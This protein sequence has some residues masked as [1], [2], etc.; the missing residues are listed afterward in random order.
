M[1]FVLVALG[2][3]LPSL[4]GSLQA[5]LV[6]FDAPQLG[7]GSLAEIPGLS[8]SLLL[9]FFV[10]ASAS[11]LSL[12]MALG[13][14]Y[15]LALKSQFKL[16]AVVVALWIAIPHV[17]FAALFSSFLVPQSFIP[18]PQ[19]L[20][21]DPSGLG[22][23]FTLAGK[24]IPFLLLLCLGGLAQIP[25]RQI[26]QNTRVLGKS[27]QEAYLQVILPM[28]IP[29]IRFGFCI[30]CVYS[31]S[32]LDISLMIGPTNPPILAQLIFEYFNQASIESKQL[33]SLLMLV[34]IC[35]GGL[36]ALLG[37]AVLEW[38]KKCLQASKFAPKLLTEKLV[39]KFF[40]IGFYVLVGLLAVGFVQLVLWSFAWRWEQ[41]A[42]LPLELSLKNWD[43]VFSG[44][45][46]DALFNSL[47]LGFLTASIA[48]LL[49]IGLSL[50]RHKSIPS[51]WKFFFLMPL[52]IPQI[53]LVIGAWL[54]FA[55]Y[56]LEFASYLQLLSFHLLYALAYL[57]FFVLPIVDR[58]VLALRKQAK[59]LQK[60]DG[61][62]VLRVLLP[63]LQRPLAIGFA[64][65]F[66]VSLELFTPNILLNPFED[67]LS[68]LLVNQAQYADM[69]SMSSLSLLQTSVVASLFFMASK[70]TKPYLEHAHTR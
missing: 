25:R 18:L 4:Y 60:Q 28:L 13:F 49:M 54:F 20:L 59:S 10:G 58:F 27:D 43:R 36:V 44:G 5:F 67:T 32:A 11:L 2:I 61:E 70:F 14:F 65:G 64:I 63:L 9:S 7:L 57:S 40:Q 23:I 68:I 19:S 1:L 15:A 16:M 21:R 55:D 41:D 26:L 37:L 3:F 6:F 56:F 22:L 12:F 48:S 31:A 66:A 29:K 34:Q 33:A 24:E 38:L 47:V 50:F 51:Y 17:S 30:I 39:P 46:M 8:S 62:I 52:L 35:L 45:V 42:F 53:V 69:R